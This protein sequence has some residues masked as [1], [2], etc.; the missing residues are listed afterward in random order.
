M[1]DL[2]RGLDSNRKADALLDRR[3]KFPS[4]LVGSLTAEL[5]LCAER[6]F[7]ELA[8]CLTDVDSAESSGSRWVIH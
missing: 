1:D 4:F 6:Y 2:L 7:D 8:C 3:V 5:G